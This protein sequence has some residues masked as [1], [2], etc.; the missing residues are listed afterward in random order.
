METNAPIE[1]PQRAKRQ[2]KLRDFKALAVRVAELERKL[3]DLLPVEEKPKRRRRTR[4]E[5]EEEQKNA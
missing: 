4:A 5:M 1:I 2:V 3:A